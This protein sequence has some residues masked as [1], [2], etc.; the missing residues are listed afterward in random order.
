MLSEQTLILILLLLL[1]QS[2][3]ATLEAS[4]PIWIRQLLPPIKY[5]YHKRIS[6]T[7]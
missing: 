3:V 2:Y 6:N 4:I 5:V 7:P 1:D